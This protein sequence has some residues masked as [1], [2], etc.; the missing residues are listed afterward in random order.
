MW[1]SLSDEEKNELIEEFN[2][3]SS[4]ESYKNVSD[5]EDD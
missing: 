5:N 2:T 3:P 4:N 1:N